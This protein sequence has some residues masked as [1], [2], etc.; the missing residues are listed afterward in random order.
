MKL[1]RSMFL[2]ASA[3][4]GQ[5]DTVDLPGVVTGTKAVHLRL[6]TVLLAGFDHGIAQAVAALI[7]VQ[8][9]LSGLPAGIPYGLAVFDI[10]VTSAGIHGQFVVAVAG[11][12]E[13]LG[14]LVEGVAA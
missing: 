4:V 3:P 9:R 10:I 6:Q 1:N 7:A 14:I 11:Q 13:K 12:T 2:G 5:G 8:L